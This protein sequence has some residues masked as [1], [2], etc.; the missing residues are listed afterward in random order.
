MLWG[1]SILNFKQ[2]VHSYIRLIKSTLKYIKSAYVC[3]TV[4]QTVPSL[5]GTNSQHKIGVFEFKE[6]YQAV[7]SDTIFAL[8]EFLAAVTQASS[9]S[10]P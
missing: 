3:N 6:F 7:L 8:F 5:Y 9:E 10:A 2:L 1:L 4:T